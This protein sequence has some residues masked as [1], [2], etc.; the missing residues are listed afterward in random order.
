MRKPKLTSQAA[1][2]LCEQVEQGASNAAAAA[3][4]GINKA[5]LYRWLARGEQE[6][7]GIYSEFRTDFERARAFRQIHFAQKIMR[8]ADDDWRAAAWLLSRLYPEDFSRRTRTEISG[9][10]QGPIQ[11]RTDIDLTPDELF[12]VGQKIVETAD[13]EVEKIEAEKASGLL[14]GSQAAA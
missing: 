5:T 8:A 14:E 9:P 4:A 13:L 10:D 2:A 11:H 12:R 7:G 1:A 6:D 3:A